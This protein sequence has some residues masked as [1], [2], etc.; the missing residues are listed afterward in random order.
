LLHDSV[1]NYFARADEPMTNDNAHRPD[2]RGGLVVDRDITAITDISREIQI[3]DAKMGRDG[4]FYHNQQRTTLCGID[5][6][7]AI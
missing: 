5:Q 1:A 2:G 4:S 7:L 6:I 3:P